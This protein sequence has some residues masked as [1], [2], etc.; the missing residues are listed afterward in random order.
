LKIREI[1]DWQNLEG[2]QNELCM[3]IFWL[4]CLIFVTGCS[5][6]SRQAS[7]KFHP[8]ISP[9]DVR[10][11]NFMPA[12]AQIVGTVKVN[13]FY[14]ATWQQASDDALDK[15]KIEAAKLGA[16]G[17][18]VNPPDDKASEGASLQG[19]AIYISR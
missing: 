12:R 4:G 10:I 11:Y 8:A 16:N 19:N 17:I 3:K 7:G 14:G 6:S 13:S 18:V 9:D 5:T 15:L 1:P 2:D